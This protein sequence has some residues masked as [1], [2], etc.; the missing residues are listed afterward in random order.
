MCAM[1]AH[2]C[3]TVCT[4]VKASEGHW[5]SSSATLPYSLETGPLTN[6]GAQLASSEVAVLRLL[7]HSTGVTDMLS[8]MPSPLC[9]Y[10]RFKL[11]SS[12]LHSS[13]AQNPA[14][15]L[16]DNAPYCKWLVTS[17]TLAN[18]NYLI[19]L[20]LIERRLSRANNKTTAI[21]LKDS[22]I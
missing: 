8:A 14:R 6:P 18:F 3:S 17:P 9:G 20:P 16:S 19:L 5:L 15:F 13:L 22:F 10:W 7:S 12:C 11:K 2:V 1:C 4:R 21:S